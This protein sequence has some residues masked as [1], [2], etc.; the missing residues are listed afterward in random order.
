MSENPRDRQVGGDHYLMLELDPWRVLPIW[1]KKWS[2]FDAYL[3]G[4]IVKYLARAPLKGELLE[5]LKKAQHYLEELI[6]RIED[7]EYTGA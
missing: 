5:D 2:G 6:R 3:V 7:G 1:L 4:N